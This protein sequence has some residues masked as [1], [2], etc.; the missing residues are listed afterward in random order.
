MLKIFNSKGRMQKNVW[1]ANLRMIYSGITAYNFTNYFHG[2]EVDALYDMTLYQFNFHTANAQVP[3][4][5][6]N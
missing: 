5:F 2:V 6:N 3:V 4:I 1:I